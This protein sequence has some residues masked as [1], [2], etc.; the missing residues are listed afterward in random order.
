MGSR[1]SAHL[2]SGGKFDPAPYGDFVRTALVDEY[3][4]PQ[5][6]CLAS[7]VLITDYS[8]I[9]FDFANTRKPMVF[10]CPDM[11]E[12]ATQKRGFYF[13]PQE[14][15]PGPFVVTAEEVSSSIDDLQ[16]YEAKYRAKYDAFVEE[17]CA[18]EDGQ[19]S[20]RVADILGIKSK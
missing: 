13:D 15:F 4:D 16:N 18:W 14:K 19:A 20:A 9:C 7:D 8:S 11:E 3:D 10:Y 12:Y 17:F 1:G 5:E 2:L 6:L